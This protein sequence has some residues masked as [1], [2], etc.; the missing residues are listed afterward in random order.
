MTRRNIVNIDAVTR[1]WNPGNNSRKDSREGKRKRERER[2]DL[3]LLFLFL[4]EE[5]FLIYLNAD[6]RRNSNQNET[7]CS[8]MKISWDF[9][10]FL[11]ISNC[12]NS[13]LLLSCSSIFKRIKYEKSVRISHRRILIIVDANEKYRTA[14]GPLWD[15]FCFFP[16][17]SIVDANVRITAR[18]AL[19]GEV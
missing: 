18:Y 3:I 17:P 6:I 4:L 19:F 10:P 2:E 11:K 15:I 1:N 16:S 8:F 12:E 7:C 9:R 5:N 14:R 13:K